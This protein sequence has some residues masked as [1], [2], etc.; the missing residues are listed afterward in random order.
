MCTKHATVARCPTHIQYMDLTLQLYTHQVVIKAP[1]FFEK[2]KMCSRFETLTIALLC[3][4]KLR[5]IWRHNSFKKGES[6]SKVWKSAT[7]RSQTHMHCCCILQLLIFITQKTERAVSL[8][9]RSGHHPLFFCLLYLPAAKFGQVILELG[10]RPLTT[11][12]GKC[13]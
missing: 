5:K 12:T 4:G 10:R 3:T 6:F 2:L 9:S 8:V 7:T 1:Y 13:A 11:Q